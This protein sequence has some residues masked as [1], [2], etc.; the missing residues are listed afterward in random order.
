MQNAKTQKASESPPVNAGVGC[1]LM[2]LF[3]RLVLH[4]ILDQRL[5]PIAQDEDRKS[6]D[7]APLILNR[8]R[9]NIGNKLLADEQ[10]HNNE[11]Y[12]GEQGSCNDHGII[13]IVKAV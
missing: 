13:R 5:Q 11:R 7:Y 6:F 2:L 9:R 8:A 3:L 12:N 1:F 10:E 4:F